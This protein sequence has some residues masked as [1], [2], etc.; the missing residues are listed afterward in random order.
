[1]LKLSFFKL[2]T[3]LCTFNSTSLG[4]CEGACKTKPA[5]GP[6]GVQT[7]TFDARHELTNRQY[8]GQGK[9]KGGSA[10]SLCSQS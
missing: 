8:T 7:S 5:L 1:M 4:G 10:N 3:S 2:K 6:S 9:E